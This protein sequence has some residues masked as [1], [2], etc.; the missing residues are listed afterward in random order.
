MKAETENI[1]LLLS[2]SS[3]LITGQCPSKT[4]TLESLCFCI[5]RGLAE[6]STAKS[7]VSLSAKPI[8]LQIAGITENM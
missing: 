5:K 2:P 6:I 8:I 1:L 7:D 3:S 4:M